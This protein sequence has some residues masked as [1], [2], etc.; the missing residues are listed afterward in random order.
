MRSMLRQC[1]G[2]ELNPGPHSV[3]HNAVD[4]AEIGRLQSLQDAKRGEDWCSSILQM[5]RNCDYKL[6]HILLK[7]IKWRGVHFVVYGMGKGLG[8]DPPTSVLRA[9]SICVCSVRNHLVKTV[10]HNGI[11]TQFLHIGLL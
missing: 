8:E 2:S 3:L 11:Q 1:E 7:W 9:T 5:E 10:G 4:R 6:H